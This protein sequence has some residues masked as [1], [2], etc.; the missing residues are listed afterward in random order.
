MFDG[1]MEKMNA[2]FKKLR[3]KGKLTPADVKEGMRDIRMA[4]LEAD[5]NYKVVK[6]FINRV[7]ERAVGAEVLE[8]I[9]PG[10]QI[11][12]I[13]DGEMTKIMGETQ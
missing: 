3:S 11:V 1:L 5:V 8:S 10:V 4:L 12:K 6:E 2:A 9:Q 7:T 13:V